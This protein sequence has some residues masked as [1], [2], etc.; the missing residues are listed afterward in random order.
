MGKFPV[1][2]ALFEIFVQKTGYM[3]TAEKTGYGTVFYGRT[4]KKV[5]KKTGLQ[6]LTWNSSL[7]NKEVKLP[8]LKGG[9]S[10]E[11]VIMPF[12][13]CLVGGLRHF[14]TLRNGGPPG[15][16]FLRNGKNREGGGITRL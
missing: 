6:K 8:A 2:N 13:K 11:M 9:A 5:D 7:I 3:T 14:R 16:P 15:F 4:Q 10:Q 1:T 12:L